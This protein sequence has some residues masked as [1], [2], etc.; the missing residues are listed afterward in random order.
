MWKYK[1]WLSHGILL[2]ACIYYIFWLSISQH[3][4]GCWIPIHFLIPAESFLAFHFTAFYWLLNSYKFC[5][6]QI[7]H[8]GSPFHSILLVVK[9]LE[10]LYFPNNSF[11]LAFSQDFTGCRIPTCFAIPKLFI[12]ALHFTAFYWLSNSYKL[13]ISQIIPFGSPFHSLLLVIKFLC[14]LY[15]KNNFWALIHTL[16]FIFFPIVQLPL[17]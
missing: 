12:L 13:C 15:L 14:M 2:V 10:V 4:T 9:F 5:T 7:I 11:W 1:H 6:S 16:L 8:L 17:Q 3:F